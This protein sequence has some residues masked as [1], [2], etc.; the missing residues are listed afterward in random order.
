MSKKSSYGS[1]VLDAMHKTLMTDN[2]EMTAYN[3]V[4]GYSTAN[5]N[6]KWLASNMSYSGGEYFLTP[7][8]KKYFSL[9]KSNKMMDIG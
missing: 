7:E 8:Q 6:S 1:A 5:N 4:D 3:T 9:L 2:Q